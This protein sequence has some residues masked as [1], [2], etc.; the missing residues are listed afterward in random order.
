M[1]AL[2]QELEEPSLPTA[3]GHRLHPQG[4]QALERT[5]NGAL[6]VIEVQS[7]A[8]AQRID[9]RGPAWR[10]LN[11]ASGFQLQQ[12]APN[13]HVLEPTGTVVPV[14]N[15]TQLTREPR[16]IR[17]RMGLQPVPNLPDVSG[18]ER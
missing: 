17:A 5:F 11:V 3:W 8:I 15:P 1:I 14:P 10:Q 2:H 9:R 16:A 18:P 13:S 12:Q 7:W 4:L 6:V